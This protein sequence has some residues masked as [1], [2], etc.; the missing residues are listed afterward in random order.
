MF[1]VHRPV[2]VHI[3][4]LD[5]HARHLGTG[6]VGAVGRGGDEA[7]VPVSLPNA[8]Q[9]RHDG[10]QTCVLPLGPTK[11][12]SN[13]EFNNN[14]Y[15]VKQVY[16]FSISYLLQAELISEIKTGRPSLACTN[17]ILDNRESISLPKIS[18]TRRF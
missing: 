6:G 8:V 5:P 13:F 1:D 14:F 12:K 7:H 16:I 11:Q 2:F 17:V 4:R 18:E 15:Y 3:D 10:A 9:I